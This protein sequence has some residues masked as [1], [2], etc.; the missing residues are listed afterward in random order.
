MEY[1]TWTQGTTFSPGWT[2]WRRSSTRRRTASAWRSCSASTDRIPE[3]AQV[4]RVLMMELNRISSHLVAIAHVR[5]GAGRDH[6]VP[7]YGFR[8]RE[9][10]L[11]LFEYDHRP[12]DE[13]RLHPAGRRRAGPAR[14]RGRQDRRVPQARCR[15]RIKDMRKLLD[16]NPVY[17]GRTKDVAYLDLTGCMA[18]GVTGPDAARRRPAVGPAQVAALLRLRDL[19]LRRADRRTPATSTAAT[20]SGWRRW[21]SRSRSSSS[22]LD[23]LIAGPLKGDPVMI[24]DKKIGWPA[25]LALGPDGLGNSPDHIAHIMGQ[26][27]GGPHPPL[28]A[29]DRGLPGAGRPGLRAGRVARAASSA[30]R[31]QRRRHP[32]V[33]RALP[34]PV[35]HQPAGRPR[36][37]RGRPGRR[38]DRGGGQHRPG[39]GRCGPVTSSAAKCGSVSNADAKEIIGRY[40]RPRSALLPLLHLVQSE[41]GYVSDDGIE[42]CAEH[43]RHHQGRGRRRRR[44]STPCTSASPV[45]EYHV[46]VCINTLCAVMGG[47]QIWERA[48]RARRRRPRRDHRRTARSAW[49]AWS[50]TRPATSPRS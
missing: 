16:A 11:D 13:P 32:P 1:R 9:K 35:V 6:A 43:A 5:P 41:D 22:A 42:F 50:A 14:G 36:D 24:E 47:D 30:P 3:R 28:Q 29:G 44:P 27:H 12:A 7:A 45:G 48:H 49:S 15:E 31:G 38:R 26:L 40:P 46:G 20:W 10:V 2:T 37:V 39:D 33:P 19:R 8:E 4:I 17:V 25:Q 23:R 18:L 34:R 21:R